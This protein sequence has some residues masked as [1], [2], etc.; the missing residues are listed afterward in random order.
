MEEI[1]DYKASMMIAVTEYGWMCCYYITLH[2]KS[3]CKEDM[4]ASLSIAYQCIIVMNWY[5][6]NCDYWNKSMFSAC[7]LKLF[8]LK[9]TTYFNNN[10]LKSVMKDIWTQTIVIYNSHN[11][12]WHVCSPCKLCLQTYCAI[13]HLT[14]VVDSMFISSK[15][16]TTKHNFFNA[17]YGIQS[18][19]KIKDNHCVDH[20]G[21]WNQEQI[22]E[23]PS[24]IATTTG[25]GMLVSGIIMPLM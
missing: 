17:V 21:R 13:Y 2:T 15:I 14:E 8:E 9:S 11:I 23:T 6:A 12:W 22:G 20:W 25:S 18:C 3:F 19:R 16:D 24:N 7:C 1:C 4:M 5:H 10:D